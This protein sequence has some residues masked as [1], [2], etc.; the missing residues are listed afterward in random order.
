MVE[1]GQVLKYKNSGPDVEVSLP[2][3][4][5]NVI[6]SKYAYVIRIEGVS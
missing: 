3:F 1:S 6:K 4:D 2:V 5:P